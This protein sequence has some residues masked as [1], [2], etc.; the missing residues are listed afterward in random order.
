MLFDS[1]FKRKYVL[2]HTALTDEECIQSKGKLTDAG[3]FHKTKIRGIYA[4]STRGIGW[5]RKQSQYDIFVKIE[6]E[7]KAYEA[8]HYS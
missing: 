3:I 6:D 7:H 8:I 1:I 5:G 2:I 4:S